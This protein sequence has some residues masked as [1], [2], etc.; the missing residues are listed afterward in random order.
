MATSRPFAY[1]TGALIP[2][3]TQYGSLAVGTPSSGF[4]STGLQW[5]MGPD[6]DLGYVI[7]HPTPTGDQPNPLSIPAYLGFWRSTLKTDASFLS[8][9]NLIGGQ[10]FANGSAAK[11]W[12]ESNGYWTSWVSTVNYGSLLGSAINNSWLTVPGS[13]D[14]APGTGDFTVEWF[15]YQTNN[16]NENFIFNV[17]ANIFATSVASGGNKLNVYLGGSKV[18]NPTIGPSLSVWYH[19][20]VS[21]SGSTLN[22]YFNG[23]RVDTL[24]NSTN[25]ND[26][27]STLFIATQNSTSPYGD[28]WPGN[29]TNFRLINGTALY[30]GS[31]LTIPTTNLTAVSNTKLLLLFETSATLLTDSSGTSKVV[32][33][34]G[35]ITWSSLTPF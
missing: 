19:T 9:A 10:T 3:T 2:G 33:N 7:A 29:I 13:S 6:E 35:S 15:Q 4:A 32:T 23:S 16:G 31:T 14:F 5:W 8:L 22:V 30:T 26:S 17:G 34:A 28:N 21:R 20:A 11:T 24:S 25:I 18:A 12:L 27:A 1:N